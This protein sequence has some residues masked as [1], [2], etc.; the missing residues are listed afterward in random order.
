MLKV[1][2]KRLDMEGMLVYKGAV[3]CYVNNQKAWSEDSKNTRFTERQ[4]RLDGY[5]LK[6][7][8]YYR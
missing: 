2:V 6:Q 1:K 4:A 8:I 7:A 3:D 5:N